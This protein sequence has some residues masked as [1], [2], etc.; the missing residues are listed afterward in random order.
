MKLTLSMLALLAMT[1]AASA[2]V[3]ATGNTG[4]AIGGSYSF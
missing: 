2:Q 3:I 1:S 4:A